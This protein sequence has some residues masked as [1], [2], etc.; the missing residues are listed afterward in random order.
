MCIRK[1][2]FPETTKGL[3][4]E[5]FFFVNL[6]FDLYKPTLD[7]LRFFYPRLHERGLILIHDFF[8]QTF[9]GVSQ[10]V[11]DFEKEIGYELKK[12]PIGD[13]CSIAIIKT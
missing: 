9:Y 5:K 13:R 10:A 1:G 8:T 2:Y 6:D 3:E 11:E 12:L 4:S 7:G